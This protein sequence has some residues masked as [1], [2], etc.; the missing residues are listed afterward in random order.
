[1][2]AFLLN[3]QVLYRIWAGFL[4]VVIL[5]TRKIYENRAKAEVQ[6]GLVQDL[7]DK[8]LNAIESLL[9]TVSLVAILAYI[10]NP[11]WVHGSAFGMAAWLRG[12]GMGSA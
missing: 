6:S 5:V 12:L 8:F 2:V 10:I 9:L 1:M 7:D 11:I 4:L 3:N